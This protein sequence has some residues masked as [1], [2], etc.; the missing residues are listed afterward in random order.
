MSS[1]QERTVA[2]P[3]G[4]I[5]EGDS[6]S[7]GRRPRGRAVVALTIAVAAGFVALHRL[8]PI[9]GAI[10]RWAVRLRAEHLGGDVVREL[11]ALQ[12]YGQGSVTVLIAWA[13]WLLQPALRRRLLDWLLAIGI[14]AVVGYPAK[15]L[16]GRPRPKFGDPEH[17]LGP[18]GTYPVSGEVGVRHA[19]EM[20]SGIS[21][22]LWS[23]PSSHTLF[24]VVMSSM[25]WVWYPR[26]RPVAVLMAAV[27]GVS[28]VLFGAH[29]PTDVLVGA[30]LGVVIAVPVARTHA[31][32]RLLDSAWRR[33]VSRDADPALPALL[34]AER[35]VG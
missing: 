25:L 17:F 29:Y 27:V 10:S 2:G 21:S 3:S 20:G 7:G 33:L 26:L 30:A 8:V 13:I 31:G 6:I 1:N 35:A 32:V 9:D 14:A 11:E 24:A 22:D 12:Q 4:K 16:I 18:F 34:A 28:R 23:M 15:M 5:A 19:W